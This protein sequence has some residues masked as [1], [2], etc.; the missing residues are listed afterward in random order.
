MNAF[1]LTAR[2][3]NNENPAEEKLIYEENNLHYYTPKEE[4]LNTATHALGIIFGII[5]FI[6]MLIKA[7]SPSAYATAVLFSIGFTA[8]YISSSMYHACTNVKI[9][10][11]LRRV[12]YCSV[13]FI[14]I[15]C[16]TG[17][18]LMSGSVAGYAIYGVCFGFSAISIILCI[19]NFKKFRMLAFAMNF[20]IG[21]A[22]FSCYFITDVELSLT[23]KLLN[24]AGIAS[25][26]IGAAIFGIKKPYVHTVFHIFVL[27]GPILFWAANYLMLS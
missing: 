10:S 17:V 13:N 21:A 24:A 20:I 19:V 8:L 9:K 14:V 3:K 27:L 23:V 25:V 15:S 7:T 12:D 26:L 2:L 11:V 5:G 22:L 1:D 6:F 18:A 16:G 4:L